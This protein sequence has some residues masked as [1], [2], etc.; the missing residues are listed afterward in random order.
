M[1]IPLTYIILDIMITLLKNKKSPVISADL[2]I[3]YLKRLI[4]ILDFDKEILEDLIFDFNFEEELEDFLDEYEEYF[5]LDEDGNIFLEEGTS[6]NKLTELLNTYCENNYFDK[7][8]FMDI[9]NILRSNVCFLEILGIRTKTDIY[10]ALLEIE[11]EIELEYLELS[12]EN[13]VSKIDSKKNKDRIRILKILANTMYINMANNLTM[14]EQ[15]NL[16]LYADNQSK[17]MKGEGESINLCYSPKFD[18]MLLLATPMDRALFIN[19]TTSTYTLKERMSNNIKKK[20]KKFGLDDISK[21]NFYLKFL[22]LLNKEI[23]NIKN[24]QIKDDLILSKYRF[25]YALDSSYDLM[26]YNKEESSI[27]INGNYNFILSIVY[28]YV[29]EI[30]S[31]E[32]TDYVIEGTN[33]EDIVTYYFNIIKKLYIQTY[34]ELTSDKKII[35]MIKNNQY[36]DKNKISTKLFDSFVLSEEEKGKVKKRSYI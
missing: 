18:K 27:D 28:F 7:E 25:M 34:Y 15:E 4:N 13:V 29:S 32:D 20:K 11:E 5:T 2:L 36:Y 23:D 26:N 12:Y 8:F 24:E 33:E 1:D 31:Y 16:L 10:D 3:I 30:L 19:D 35:D 9:N 17:P 6:I 14:K 21:I 22:E